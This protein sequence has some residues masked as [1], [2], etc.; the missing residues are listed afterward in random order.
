MYFSEEL[1]HQ[2]EI[3]TNYQKSPQKC[4]GS[5]HPLPPGILLKNRTKVMAT[6]QL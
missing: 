5:K 3:K 2:G 6:V 4:P 1:Q